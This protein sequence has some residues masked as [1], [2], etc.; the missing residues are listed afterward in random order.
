M[1]FTSLGSGSSGNGLV[2]ESA[3]TRVLMDCGFGLAETKARLERAG[4]EPS[5]ITAIVVTHEHDDH[6][7]GVARFALRYAIPVYL[8]RGTS[9]WLP[10]DF[11]AVLVRLIDPHSAFSIDAIAVDPIAVPHDAREPVQYVFSDGDARLGVVTDLGTVT[12]HVVE[13]LSGC[14][15]LVIECNHDLDMLMTGPY[16]DSL[17]RRVAGRFGHLSNADAAHLVAALDRG[18]LRHLIAAHLSQQNNTPALAVEALARGAS[19]AREWIG[20]AR[21]DEGFGWRDA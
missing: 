4:L 18:R 19:C 21:Q 12:Q 7:S 9:Q 17:K 11:P 8:T 20:V 6:M 5:Q 15:A 16:P 3:G 14:E 10:E 13:K 2:V 1:R